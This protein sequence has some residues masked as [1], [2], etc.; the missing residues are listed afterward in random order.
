MEPIPIGGSH[1]R[2]FDNPFLRDESLAQRVSRSVTE[3]L[4]YS[5]VE[6]LTARI[7]N[8]CA[9]EDGGKPPTTLL[10]SLPTHQLPFQVAPTLE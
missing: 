2:Y 1:R 3:E 4:L 5:W 9:G 6:G 10:T 8:H 7:G